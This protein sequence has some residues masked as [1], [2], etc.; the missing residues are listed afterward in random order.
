MGLAW[1][2]EREVGHKAG[3]VRRGKYVGPG[4]HI[5][6]FGLCQSDM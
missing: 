6:K 5:I 2:M 1:G 3:K 4:G